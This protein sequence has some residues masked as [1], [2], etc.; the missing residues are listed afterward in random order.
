[1]ASDATAFAYRESEVMILSPTFLP[2][3]ASEEEENAALKTWRSI[4]VFGEGAYSGFMSSADEDSLKKIFPPETYARLAQ[5][6][7]QY[8][9]NNV[10]NQNYNIKPND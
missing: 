10:F 2:I 4:E 6:K 9:P 7:K 1:M 3:T 8:D 5:I